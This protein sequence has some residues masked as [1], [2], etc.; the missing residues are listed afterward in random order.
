M[1]LSSAMFRLL[2]SVCL[3]AGVVAAARPPE[4]EPATVRGA[5]SIQLPLGWK[6]Q[7]AANRPLLIAAAPQTDSDTTGKFQASLSINQDAGKPID[8]DA[9]KAQQTLLEKNVPGY[10]VVEKPTPTVINGMQGVFFGGTSKIGNVE[11]FS[12]QYM[13]SVNNQV[14]TLT[15]TCLNSL[16]ATYKP[17]VEASVGTFTVK[18]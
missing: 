11:L 12:R 3:L 16:W 6:A 8:V 18:K 15:F 7:P 2:A 13:F 17:V 4:L 9:A 10:H 5:V 1:K 14:Y